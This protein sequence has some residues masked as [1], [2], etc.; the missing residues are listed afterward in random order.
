[1]PRRVECAPWRA[2]AQRRTHQARRFT[3]PRTGLP[4]APFAGDFDR[5]D[6]AGDEFAGDLDDLAGDFT[7]LAGDLAGPA[8]D[9]TGAGA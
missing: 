5:V 6:L 4:L 3:P 8:G 7:D 1:M 9:L 2:R